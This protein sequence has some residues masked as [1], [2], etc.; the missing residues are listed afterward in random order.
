[1]LIAFCKHAPPS[2]DFEVAVF[3]NTLVRLF[4]M[5]H[6][7]A[8]GDVEDCSD[9]MDVSAFQ[10]FQMELIDAAAIDEQ[11]LNVIRQSEAKVE[12]IFQWIQQLIVENIS[13]G[14]MS[15]PPPILTRS[16]QEMASGMVHFH[17]ALKISTVPFPFPY[18]QA[19]PR[20]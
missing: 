16:F 8:L 19:A 5:L 1:A 7:A 17:N 18:A 20:E 12:L 11:S 15:I 3:Q 2:K 6:S 14:V 4:S 9:R 10:A 13:T